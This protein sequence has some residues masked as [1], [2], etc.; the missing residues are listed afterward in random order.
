MRRA[1]P[2]LAVLLAGCATRAPRV[3][4]ALPPT[5]AS[6]QRFT[7]G[8]FGAAP[9]A[10]WQTR[11]GDP[12]LR[13]LVDAALLNSPDLEAAAA[14]I[15]QGR[16][17]LRA[18]EAERRPNIGALASV[19][20][21]RAATAEGFG[22]GGDL[23]PGISIDRE[24]V[25]ARTGVDA[26]YDLDL[27]G[28]LRADRRAAAL[29]LDA[30]TADA[31]DVRLALVTDV[32]RNYVSAAAADDRAAVAR[33]NV[34]A[35]RDLLSVTR[36]RVRAG[37]VAG[38]D[39]ARAEGLLA[40]AAANLPLLEGERAARIAA[41]TTLTGLSPAEIAP[42]VAAASPRLNLGP[43][44]AGVPSEVVARRPDVAAAIAR[45]AAADADTAAA[46]ARRYPSLS[47]TGSI[48]LV[49]NLLGSVF[50]GDPFSLAAGPSLAG[51]LLDGGRN[52]AA[53]AG[54]RARTAE[55]VANYR[56][57]VLGAFGE[58][59]QFVALAQA[60]DRQ[61]IAL[62]RLA[63]ANADTVSIARVQY[64]RGLA[65]FLG[66]LD[67]QRE[68]F[69]ARDAAIQAAAAAADAELGLF[70]AVGG[71]LPVG[72]ATSG[73]ARPPAGTSRAPRSRQP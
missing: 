33:E 45:V 64:R 58:V 30:A 19:A 48:G 37:L 36:A 7:A 20:G 47:I 50:A 35:A 17:E 18:R 4:T 6:L 63:A 42:A 54:A 38:I 5:P 1:L 41:L 70:R 73:A 10:W 66:V 9:G 12:G 8:P 34:A 32:A 57:A 27:F 22:G 23:P 3:E 56:R 61:R 60:R 55:A 71:D 31:A 68:L 11:L 39:E 40:E 2:L 29:R 49:F 53:V 24:R 43:P 15:E 46:L 59:E 69:R 72:A 21:S 26:S 62:D 65:D 44:A 28:R 16:A 67:A 51:P 14:R 13:R 52:R 25:L